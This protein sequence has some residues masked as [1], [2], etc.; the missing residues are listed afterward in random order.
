MPELVWNPV[1]FLDALETVPM[2]GEYGTYFIYEI[3]RQGLRL[4]LSVHPLEGDVS[5]QIVCGQQAQPV[6]NLSLLNCPSARV[7][8]DRRGTSIEFAAA[9][10]FSGRFDETTAAPFGFRL[11]VQ[12]FVQI[13][14]YSYPG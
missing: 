1:D 13:E 12:P 7:I 8:K 3:E 14:P 6:L 4:K 10:A 2:E 5:I 9:N 11:R